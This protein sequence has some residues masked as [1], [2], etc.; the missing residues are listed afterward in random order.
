MK[1]RNAV[2]DFGAVLIRWNPRAIIDGF[3]DDAALRERLRSEVF[4]H[5]DWLEMDRGS[6]DEDAA[7][8]RF[9]Q[10]MGRPVAEMHALL[11]HV[12]AS[13]SPIEESFAI[14]ADLK[15][16]GIPVYGLSNMPPQRMNYLR[17]RFAHWSALDGMVISG[18]VKLVKPDPAIYRLLCARFAIAPRQSVFI[19]DLLPNVQAAQALGF[20]GVHFQ[21]PEQCARELDALFAG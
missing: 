5:P 13:L 7:A 17:E 9:A 18:E 12:D 8:E 3:Y 11:R 21:S 4:A 6:F 15:R 2:F 19:D 14:I 16:R 20:H 10:R 1:P